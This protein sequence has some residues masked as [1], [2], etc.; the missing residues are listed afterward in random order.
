MSTEPKNPKSHS[1][2]LLQLMLRLLLTISTSQWVCHEN[3]NES[4][5]R[6][7]RK[8]VV[9]LPHTPAVGVC[10]PPEGA[11]L[12]KHGAERSGKRFAISGSGACKEV[13][14][15]NRWF[16]VSK[17]ILVD[18]TIGIQWL[19]G[20]TVTGELAYWLQVNRHRGG[21]IFTQAFIW[22]VG[23]LALTMC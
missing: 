15:L 23:G 14:R 13:E 2:R 20:R 22:N 5:H 4:F 12:K 3:G 17:V 11:V 9:G 21:K 7:V 18:K 16:Y 1:G 8:M 6:T 19:I 10:K